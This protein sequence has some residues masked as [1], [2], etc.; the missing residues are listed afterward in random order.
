MKQTLKPKA[1]LL[2][3]DPITMEPLKADG[4]PKEMNSYWR[5]RMKDG[6]VEEVK[7]KSTEE[8]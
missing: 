1:G 2:V 3:R 5:R 8:K 4:D 6:E 7:I